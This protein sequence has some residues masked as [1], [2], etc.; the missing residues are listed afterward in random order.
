MKDCIVRATAANGNIR[1]FAGITTDLVSLAQKTHG[2]SPVASAALGRTMTAAVMMGID[3]KGE[4]HSLSIALK[5]GGPIGNV[6]VVTK[7]NGNTK[8]YVDNPSLELPLNSQGKLDVAK[9]VGNQGKL[10]VIK[11][12]GLKEPY[13]GQVDMVTGE[14]GD[15]IAYYMA[16]SEQKPSVVGL[17]VLVN[18]DASIKAA[19]GFIIQP[20]PGAP[21]ELIHTIET[22]IAEI[23]AVSSMV[24]EGKKADEILETILGDMDL[25]INDSTSPNFVC[26]CNRERLEKVLL[27]IGI[28]ELE[29]ILREDGQAELVCHYCNSAYKFDEEDIRRMIEYSKPGEKNV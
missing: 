1:A 15:D 21:E 5:G 19:G 2:L 16:I 29:D 22:R 18:P 3:M 4:D 17:G 7:S 11:D 14:I 23:P 10:T 24:D 8:G 28:K 20:L 6:I 12:L 13:A 27:T 9:G 26:D 25:K